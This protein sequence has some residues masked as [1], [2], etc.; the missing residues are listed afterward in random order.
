MEVD[1]AGD[2]NCVIRVVDHAD[3]CVRGGELINFSKIRRV[4]QS[5]FLCCLAA[6]AGQNQQQDEKE[7]FLHKSH[8]HIKQTRLS[9]GL[10]CNSK[11]VVNRQRT[12][13]I[14]PAACR[15]GLKVDIAAVCRTR[16]R[17]SVND[18]EVRIAGGRCARRATG[19]QRQGRVTARGRRRVCHRAVRR[20]TARGYQIICGVNP[21]LWLVRVIVVALKP[22]TRLKEK[23]LSGDGLALNTHSVSMVSVAAQPSCN[24]CGNQGQ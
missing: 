18:E 3:L 22:V 1:N 21:A 7:I 10:S 19:R 2:C 15:Q 5:N 17:A 23:T 12:S 24:A 20:V 8:L 11:G 14:A 6:L 13:A 9:A 16:H 4:L